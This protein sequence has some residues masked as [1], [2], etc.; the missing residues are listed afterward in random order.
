MFDMALFLIVCTLLNT[1]FPLD[2]LLP[3]EDHVLHLRGEGGVLLVLLPGRE[4]KKRVKEKRSGGG[5]IGES[6]RKKLLIKRCV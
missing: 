1:E 6:K 3:G 4:M 2:E 5:W